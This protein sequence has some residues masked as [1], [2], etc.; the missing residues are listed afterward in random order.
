[1]DR[2]GGRTQNAK[3]VPL[4]TRFAALFTAGDIWFD[5]DNYTVDGVSGKVASFVDYRDPT[6]VIS[7]P[8]AAEQ[9]AVPS[10]DA[11]LNAKTSALFTSAERYLSNRAAAAWAFLHDGTGHDAFYVYVPT[12]AG[13]VNCIATTLDANAAFPNTQV[14]YAA[15]TYTSG[16]QGQEM[17]VCNGTGGTKPVYDAG[18]GQIRPLNVGTYQETFFSSTGSPQWG[19]LNKTVSAGSGS[20]AATLSSSAPNNAL[21]LGAS[22]GVLS[23][24]RWRAMYV[25]RR[26]LTAAEKNVVRQYIQATTGVV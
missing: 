21:V 3:V 25:F 26:V 23:R 12:T 6:H 20:V 18:S 2:R 11:S 16:G 8:N 19:H 15:D 5:A 22:P 17:Y 4:A 24:M 13:A 7:Q 10:T 14:G 9:V 1:M